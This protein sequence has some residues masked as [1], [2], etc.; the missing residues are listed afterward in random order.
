M[1]FT[2]LIP[3]RMTSTRLPQKPLADIAGIPM[4]V[5]TARRAIQAGAAT[6]AVACDDERIVDACAKHDI[7]A[8]LTDPDHP[9]GTDRLSEAARILGLDENEIVV[10]VQGDEPLIP[11]KV[12]AAV[13][14][15]LA[16]SSDCAI[17]TAAHPIADTASF[18]NPNV[19][20]VELNARDRALT[21][22]R[23]PLPWPR[24]A[25]KAGPVDLPEGLPVYHHIGLYAYRAGFLAKFPTLSPAPIEK[26][27]SLEQLR[28][29]WHGYQIRVMI[30]NEKLPA[31]VDTLQD[32]ERVRAIVAAQ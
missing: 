1:Q 17:A 6:V 3:A 15:A 10:N 8:I 28:A 7:R 26:A 22:S 30:L 27:E 31:G 12:I 4:V 23:A 25:F 13:A 29:L 32:L 21:F 24:D 14:Q 11:P 9:T 5:H 2:A 19:V 16:E 18:M 20:K